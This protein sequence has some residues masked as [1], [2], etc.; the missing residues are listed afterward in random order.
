M[1]LLEQTQQQF[2]LF[3]RK[4]IGMYFRPNA[5]E[6]LFLPT[7][8]AC[9]RSSSLFLHFWIKFIIYFYNSYVQQTIWLFKVGSSR[10]VIF[11]LVSIWTKNYFPSTFQPQMKSWQLFCQFL[12]GIVPNWKYLLKSFHLYHG[13]LEKIQ[14]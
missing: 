1:G 6:L 13:F 9:F 11:N 5:L 7:Y 10:E 4:R 12:G 3:H 8:L 14:M 2:Y